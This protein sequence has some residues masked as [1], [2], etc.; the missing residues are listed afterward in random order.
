[1]RQSLTLTE[2]AAK[3]QADLESK[4]DL[5][6]PSG[7]LELS[8]LAGGVRLAVPE[9]GHFKIQ[10]LAHKQIAEYVGVPSKYYD[11]MLNDAP[12]LLTENVNN[13]LHDK[14]HRG[15]QR[16]VRM[17]GGNCRAFLSDKY[18]RVDNYDV[19]ERALQVFAD[20]KI[21]VVSAN[22]TD[23]S[24]YIQAVV[25]GLEAEVK[26]RR[27]GDVVRGGVHIRNSEVG[28]GCIEVSEYDYFLWCL[29]GAT[30]AKLM[31]KSHLG[32]ALEGNGIRWAEDTRRSADDLL[33]KQ[34]RDTIAEAI[35][36]DRFQRRIA[37]MN[38]LTKLEIEGNPNDAIEVLASVV[39]LSDAEKGGI[40]KS[41]LKGGDPSAYGLMNA[42]T[43]QAHTA[44]CDRAVELERA[45][46][47]LL[48]LPRTE[49]K[50]ILEPE[51]LAA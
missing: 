39:D 51:K 8:T 50:R 10:P 14:E 45:G 19:A 15:K 32:A 30:S 46:G 36:P 20:R 16:M 27:V 7:Q 17:L 5:V 29:N 31:R 41:L 48:E 22:V 40:L 21:E 26:S 35:D 18:L 2:L 47:K 1:M 43:E 28:L 33:M 12:Q 44:D 42:L 11:R 25:P 37:R 6:A 9:Q 13:W 23:S 49:W 3:L 38:D 4:K 24:L 34:V